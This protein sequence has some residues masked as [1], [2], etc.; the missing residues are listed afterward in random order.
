MN[1]L[2]NLLSRSNILTEANSDDLFDIDKEVDAQIKRVNNRVERKKNE[3]ATLSQENQQEQEIANSQSA[4]EESQDKDY[5]ETDTGEELDQASTDDEYSEGD[6]GQDTQENNSEDNYEYM[7]NGQT[8]DIPD[9]YEAKQTIPELK[10]LST[11]S[12]SEYA[13]CNIK[14]MEQ[15]KELQNNIESS[16]NNILINI[17]TRNDR[18]VQIV[19]IVHNNLLDM[20]Q[21]INTYILYRNNDIYEENVR[22]YLTYLKRYDIAMKLIKT[23][24]DENS[25]SEDDK[26]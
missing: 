4:D 8:D 7:D 18:Q 15:F 19:E 23:I 14:I 24:L 22:T 11:L 10:I 12:D 2:S 20:V 3:D 5:S 21:D 17:I 9:N 25:K 6:S 13:L 1:K 16:L 26:K